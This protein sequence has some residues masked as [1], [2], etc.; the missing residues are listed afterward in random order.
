VLLAVALTKAAIA[1]AKVGGTG[2][3]LGVV[4]CPREVPAPSYPRVLDGI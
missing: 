3:G 4:S 2:D 1:S